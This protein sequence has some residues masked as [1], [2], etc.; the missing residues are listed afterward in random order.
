MPRG[1]Q[2]DPPEDTQMSERRILV[3]EDEQVVRNLI[4]DVLHGDGHMVDVADNGLKALWLLRQSPYD[5]I[6]A[7]LKMPTMDG[8]DFYRE[9]EKLRPETAPRIIFVTGESH[10]A[11]YDQFLKEIGAVALTKPFA[12]RTLQRVVA[13]ALGPPR[14]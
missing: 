1:S 11:G 10:A 13:W 5:L 14:G 12:V 4:V 7:D 6:L 9:V 2:A 8:R 3:V